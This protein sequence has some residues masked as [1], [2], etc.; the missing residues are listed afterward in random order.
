MTTLISCTLLQSPPSTLQSIST[1]LVSQTDHVKVTALR[2]MYAPGDGE[3][4][5]TTG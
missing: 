5:L 1:A 2:L 4:M 3:V